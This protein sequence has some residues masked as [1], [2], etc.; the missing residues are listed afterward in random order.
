[1]EHSF[2]T[3][4]A[5]KHGLEEAVVFKN[6]CYWVVFNKAQNHNLFEGEYWTYNSATAFAEVMDY[7]TPT[8]IA[9]CLR[10]LE[11][12][13]YIKSGCF[14]SNKFN[15]SK[16]YTLTEKGWTF[17]TTDCAPVH[18]RLFK[19]EQSLNTDINTDSKQ[20]IIKRFVPPTLEEVEKYCSERHNQVDPKRFFD[21]YTVSG[22]KDSNGNSVK[23]WKQKVITWESRKRVTHGSS[24]SIDDMQRR[25]L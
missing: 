9:R 5:K 15:H 2:N 6:I 18:N 20:D 22:W 4:I 10:N 19:A 16:W 17:V 25:M 8:K 24:V 23:N 14:N 12:L 1:M 21:F 11:E 13:G 7:L 3:E